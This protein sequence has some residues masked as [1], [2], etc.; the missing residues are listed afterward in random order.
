MTGDSAAHRLQDLLG[1]TLDAARGA[2]DG[3]VTA[4]VLVRTDAGHLHLA[5][6][7]PAPDR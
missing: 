4:G 5:A 1:C 6:P 3:A 2:L 7:P